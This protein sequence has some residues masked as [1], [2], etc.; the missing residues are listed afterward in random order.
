MQRYYEVTDFDGMS[1][2]FN[3][4]KSANKAAEILKQE[5][6]DGNWSRSIDI[7]SFTL[8]KIPKK[9]LTVLLLNNIGFMANRQKTTYFER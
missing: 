5:M 1:S 2:Y 7:I 9:D 4:Y 3:N 8:P 6:I